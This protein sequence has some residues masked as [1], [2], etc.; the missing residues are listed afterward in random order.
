MIVW[1]APENFF[2][3]LL[4]LNKVPFPHKYILD[5]SESWGVLCYKRQYFL[6]CANAFAFKGPFS[7]FQLKKGVYLKIYLGILCSLGVF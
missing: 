3:M 6:F 4:I 2:K 7:I 5:V 1:V